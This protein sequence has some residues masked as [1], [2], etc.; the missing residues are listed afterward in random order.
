MNEMDCG[1]LVDHGWAVVNNA[2]HTQDAER[3]PQGPVSRASLSSASEQIPPVHPGL[4][5]LPA[6]F[7][8]RWQRLRIA[9]EDVAQVHVEQAAGLGE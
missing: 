9:A 7:H 6:E 8:R 1:L 3:G 4:Q 5:H 2:G